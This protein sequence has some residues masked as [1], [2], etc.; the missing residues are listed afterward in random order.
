MKAKPF[1]VAPFF[2]PSGEKVWQVYGRIDG[3][4]IRKNFSTRAEAV[5]YKEAKEVERLNVS[6]DVQTRATRLTAEE[7]REAEQA[8]EILRELGKP[9]TFAAKFCRKHYVPTV[10]GISADDAVE[11][12]VQK[13]EKDAKEGH[14]TEAQSKRVKTEITRFRKAFEGQELE[15]ITA[16]DLKGYLE[17]GGGSLKTWNNRRTVLSTFYKFALSER[18]IERNPIIEIPHHGKK[19]IGRKKGE[20]EVLTAEQTQKLMEFVEGYQGGRMVNFFAVTLFAGI[21]P[22][23]KN[24]EIGKIRPDHFDLDHGQI[25]LP[26]WV[27]KIGETRSITIQP[28]LK[29]W[30]QKYPF[31]QF[32]IIPPNCKKLRLAIRKKFSLGHDVLRHTFCSFLYSKTKDLGDVARQAGNSADMIRTHYSSYR[33]PEEVANFW[34]IEPKEEGKVVKMRA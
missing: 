6:R 34:A 7:I 14:I 33:Q 32:P 5:G 22:D 13:R 29:A 28:N 19:A 4:R 3:K 17:T 9:L 1:K 23:M 31:E 21:R 12:Y 10:S 8:V 2:N 24:G 26:H 15:E 20:A 16:A 30:L 11:K 27:S 25:N 18:W